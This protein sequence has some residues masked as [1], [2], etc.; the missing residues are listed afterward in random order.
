MDERRYLPEEVEAIFEAASTPDRI[1]R[2]TGDRG[3]TLTELQS[4]GS[5]VGIPA[6]DIAAAA[7]ELDRSPAPLVRRTSLGMPIAVGRTIELPRAPTDREWAMLLAELR[8]TFHAQGKDVSSGAVHGWVNGNLHAYIEPWEDGWRLRT[9]TLKG[10]AVIFNNFG[11]FF[12][13]L[14]LVMLVVGFLFPG[15]G[16][17]DVSLMF[18]LFG[19][20]AFARNALTLPRW[21]R[22]R[23]AQMEYIAERARALITG[24]ESD[25]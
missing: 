14:A 4:I 21:A 1:R 12:F 6:E 3:L 25:D 19:T 9:G 15:V 7:A 8:Q 11:F 2:R 10:E 17:L 18:A 24:P 22:E 5:E 23:D 13:A 16:E 20:G